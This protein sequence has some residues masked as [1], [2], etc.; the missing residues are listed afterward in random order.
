MRFNHNGLI[1]CLLVSVFSLSTLD[2]FA[3]TINLAEQKKEAYLL[4]AKDIYNNNNN[5]V[6]RLQTLENA[7][8]LEGADINLD[9][10]KVQTL[11]FKQD[12][13]KISNNDI[14]LRMNYL[15]D[16]NYV[17]GYL[18]KDLSESDDVIIKEFSRSILQKLDKK[19][20]LDVFTE[21]TRSNDPTERFIGIK[22]LARINSIE[23]ANI[24]I[25]MLTRASE[26]EKLLITDVLSCFKSKHVYNTALNLFNS[27]KDTKVKINLA[28]ILINNGDKKYSG[29]LQECSYSENLGYLRYL[30]FKLKDLNEPVDFSLIEKLSYQ[31]DTT[32]KLGVLSYL[33]RHKNTNE[34]VC[35][36]K[37]YI[38]ILKRYIFDNSNL[39][40]ST[41]LK[42]T[43]SYQDK[44][45]N[46]VLKPLIYDDKRL[47]F[48]TINLILGIDNKFLIQSV[49]ELSKFDNDRV[50]LQAAK[51][52]INYGESPRKLL[53]YLASNSKDINI[54]CSAIILLSKLDNTDKYI[55]SL[56]NSTDDEITKEIKDFAVLY[57]A[58]LKD[59]NIKEENL[60]VIAFDNSN[61]NNSLRAA[62]LLYD[63]NNNSGFKIIRKFLSTRKPVIISDKYCIDNVLINL[64]KD[65]NIWVK[66]NSAYNLAMINNKRGIEELKTILVNADDSRVR[67]Y[68][69]SMLGNAGSQE[70][71][72]ILTL[73]YNDKFCRVRSNAA[74]AVIEIISRYEQNNNN[75]I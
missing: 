28:V 29:F 47:S 56:I 64:L 38:K 14:K 3:S 55:T 1:C 7:A 11:F 27:E 49:Y 59:K 8:N 53:K 62:L 12:K 70:D 66:L 22:G 20:C 24:L 43:A 21:M 52:L 6:F 40:S 39:V 26:S 71:I 54:R 63:N 34:H 35:T 5:I 18:L 32:T 61:E 46:K 31:S 74:A 45:I 25:S 60:K 50:K 65:D 72:N 2:S 44:D 15:K 30:A 17:F 57:I 36:K 73:A 67:A 37:Q 23:S 10:D 33:D 4:L 41:A 13:D 68:A 75:K 9:S 16:K 58:N 69:A 51:C 19:E 48:T 42:L